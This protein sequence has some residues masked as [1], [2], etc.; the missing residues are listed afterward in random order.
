M[1]LAINL[2]AQRQGKPWRCGTRVAIGLQE[3]GDG[4]FVG[5]AA[6]PVSGGLARLLR[7]Q[8]DHQRIRMGNPAC[9]RVVQRHVKT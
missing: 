1:A 4:A 3:I 9:Q 8:F 6:I 5:F 7:A 2:H